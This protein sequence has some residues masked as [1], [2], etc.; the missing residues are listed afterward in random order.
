MFDGQSLPMRPAYFVP[1][2]LSLY[3]I[4]GALAL[5]YIYLELGLSLVAGALIGIWILQ[6]ALY[7]THSGS[8]QSGE[9]WTAKH[10]QWL[11]RFAAC[12]AVS[13]L[14]LFALVFV[15]GNQP[16]NAVLETPLTLLGLGAVFSWFAFIWAAARTIVKIESPLG[17]DL[18]A[19]T[20]GT[21]ILL[22]YIFIGAFF[23][24]RRL[25]RLRA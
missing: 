9:I 13:V 6:A 14:L 7:A 24:Y 25:E 1:A 17:A 12:S 10:S 8:S 5:R 4:G 23:V 11:R 18:L 21:F 20:L 2:I 16:K 22:V 3:V 19:P 15:L